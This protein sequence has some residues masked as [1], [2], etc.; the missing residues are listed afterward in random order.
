V[1]KGIIRTSSDTFST[2]SARSSPT[3][4]RDG[5]GVSGGALEES[6]EAESEELRVKRIA[7]RD[8]CINCRGFGDKSDHFS[9]D[10]AFL[11]E[12]NSQFR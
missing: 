1:S 8:L 9:P 3:R 11:Y 12:Q 6:I 2:L 7:F 4:R 10:G 5:G